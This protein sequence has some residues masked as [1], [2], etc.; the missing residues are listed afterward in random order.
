MSTVGKN[1]Q[2]LFLAVIV[3]AVVLG[4][5]FFLRQTPAKDG[6]AVVTAAGEL[7]G[8]YPLSKDDSYRIELPDGSYNVLEIKDGRADITEASCPD[9]ICV[10]HR[11]I[12]K[13]N[14]TIVCLP[15]ELIVTIKDAAEAEVDFVTN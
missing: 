4:S 11:R 14:Q 6:V 9:G 15:N 5:I 10:A 2:R 13:T 7:Y 12:S 1:D 3:I 8:S